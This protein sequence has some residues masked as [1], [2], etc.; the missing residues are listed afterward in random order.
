MM[1]RTLATFILLL[2]SFSAAAET[3]EYPR[4]VVLEPF[5]EMYTG[6]G[7][8][9]PVFHVVAAGDSINILKRRTSWFLIE[10]EGRRGVRGWARYRDMRK[11]AISIADDG[12]PTYANFPGY[13]R[14]SQ[15]K[16][17][18]TIAGGDFSKAAS[19]STALAYRMTPNLALQLEGTQIL[20][21]FSD[22]KMLSAS[23]Q[24]YPF[25][26]W[27]AS[28]YFQLGA[29]ILQTE[30][31]ATLV[32]ATDRTDNT[33]LVGGGVNVYL[34]RRFNLFLDY[35]RHTVLT[36]RNDNEEIDEWKLGFNVSF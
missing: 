27:R 22:G 15:S 29:G 18:W 30:P 33:L 10:T 2:S 32:Q 7:R 13:D 23:I 36:S 11:T 4:V 17:R 31:S 26:A 8:G 16:W 12:S 25:P 34:G 21:E 20:G 5:I 35:R 6:P 9:Y 1:I 3:D 14:H 24:H 19:I 28:P